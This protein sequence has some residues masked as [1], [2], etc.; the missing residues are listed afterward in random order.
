MEPIVDIYLDEE[1]DGNPPALVGTARFSLRRGQVTTSFTYSADFLAS[2]GAFAIDPAMPISRASHFFA[3]LPGALADTAP[4]RWGRR[5]IRRGWTRTPDEVD[6]ML[7]TCD[8]ARQGALRYRIPKESGFRSGDQNGAVPP[9]VQLP[10]LLAACRAV[11]ADQDAHDEVKYLLDVGSSTLGG[12]RPKASVMD[13]GVLYI[14]KFPAPSDD[15]DVLSWEK[16]AIDLS[17][18]CGIA[19][20][21][22][23]LARI[24]DE[25]VLLLR[26]FDRDYSCG[27]VRRL[28]YISAMT[29][30]A[31][32]DG[33]TRDYVELAENLAGFVGNPTRDLEELFR[34]IVFSIAVNNT[35]DHLRNHGFLR[36]GAQWLLS[37]AFDVNPNPNTD[38][39]RA[40]SILGEA[41][42][43][44]QARALCESAAEF[45]LTAK[46]AQSIVASVLRP[47]ANWRAA[48]RRNGCRESEVRLF[49]PVFAQG[50]DELRDAFGL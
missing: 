2:P 40:T 13:E 22:A 18:A 5:L 47:I 45:G 35:D 14:A 10:R 16:T 11:L 42:P 3:G 48:A 37:P 24:G 29:L 26:R 6:Y 21:Q 44:G 27:K 4:D 32:H 12:A 25:S 36:D 19:A 20:P 39:M 33:D 49:E 1:G 9:L 38:A 28:P 34:R 7:G 43:G 17:R 15:H 23:R 41:G 30:L 50:V 46:Q 31:S 8:L